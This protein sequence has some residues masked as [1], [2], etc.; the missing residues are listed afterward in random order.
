MLDR[1]ENICSAP[2]ENGVGNSLQSRDGA[3]KA[4]SPAQE[5]SAPG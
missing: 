1:A 4:P 2:D 3:A 5:D